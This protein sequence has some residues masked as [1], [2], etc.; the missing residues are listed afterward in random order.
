MQ[1]LQRHQP[2]EFDEFSPINNANTNH[3]KRKTISV[4]ER[5]YQNLIALSDARF[6]MSFDDLI[7][8]LIA[9]TKQGGEELTRHV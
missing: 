7:N 2:S 6:R 8:T 1:N 4:T 3:I 5:T 9:K